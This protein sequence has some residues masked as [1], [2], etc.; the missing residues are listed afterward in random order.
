MAPRRSA[1]C[2]FLVPTTVDHLWIH[3]TGVYCRLP[4]RR[5]RLPARSTVVRLCLTRAYVH[6]AGY[7]DGLG[8]EAGAFGYP[9][10][11][12]GHRRPV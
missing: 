3:S 2:P 9:A 6:C 5:V 7:R 12:G 8:E 1:T 10:V 11:Q 4:G